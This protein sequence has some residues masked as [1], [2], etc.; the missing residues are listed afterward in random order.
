MYYCIIKNGVTSIVWHIEEHDNKLDG[1]QY[2]FRLSSAFAETEALA[3]AREIRR[4]FVPDDDCERNIARIERFLGVLDFLDRRFPIVWQASF[5]DFRGM[6]E[7]YTRSN[8]PDGERL[9]EVATECGGVPC[10]YAPFFVSHAADLLLESLVAD[11]E[12]L[13]RFFPDDDESAFAA[14][15]RWF[16]KRTQDLKKVF[17]D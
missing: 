2:A 10:D 12:D 4:I 1:A 7:S 3:V 13:K 5:D 14:D 16:F 15:A 9:L 8:D 6:F 11:E 17:R